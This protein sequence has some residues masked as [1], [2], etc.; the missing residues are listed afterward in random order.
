MSLLKGLCKDHCNTIGTELLM[1]KDI[2][3]SHTY[4][5]ADKSIDID[6]H[7]DLDTDLASITTGQ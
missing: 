7:I 6:L 1:R 2:C 5:G 4:N 3:N